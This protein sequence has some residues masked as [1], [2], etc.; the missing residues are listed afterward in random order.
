MD[1][2]V[3]FENHSSRVDR[4]HF[5]MRS[6]PLRPSPLA[7]RLYVLSATTLIGVSFFIEALFE[8]GVAIA[9]SV[10]F[11]A[12]I[13]VLFTYFFYRVI[14]HAKQQTLNSALAYTA[15]EPNS[16][17]LYLR[18]FATS[19]KIPVRNS[20]RSWTERAITGTFWD[21]EHSL[22]IALDAVGLLVAIGD[23]RNSFG[24]A[25]LLPTDAEWQA[26]FSDLASKSKNI[27]VV[28]HASPSVVWEVQTIVSDPNLV[29]KTWFLMP[30]SYW[31][32][33]RYALWVFSP[34]IIFLFPFNIINRYLAERRWR[35]A[36]EALAEKGI[37]LPLFTTSG[38]IFQLRAD[39]RVATH[40]PF[41]DLNS[42][43]LLSLLAR[44]QAAARQKVAKPWFDRFPLNWSPLAPGFAS[45]VVI[46]VSVMLP[47]LILFRSLVF[48]SFSIPSGS[49][50]P[51]LLIGDY[52]WVSK[53]A[54]GY[55]QSSFPHGFASFSG[56]IFSVEPKRGDVVVFKLSRDNSTF[57]IKRLIGLPGDQIE[58]RDGVLYINGSAVPKR[59]IGDFVR[60]DSDGRPRRS[61]QFEETLPN[62]IRYNV[63]DD[64]ANG[65]YDNV[66]PYKVPVGHYFMM[67]DNR[68]NSTD[69][70][71]LSPRVG[72]GYVPFDNFVGRADLV[73]FSV[74]WD[75]PDA[76]LWSRPWTWPFE[77]RWG[78]T[79]KRI[80]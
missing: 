8:S 24:A 40:T 68:D 12:A 37:A 7:R 79:F 63:L 44:P 29:R 78:R 65:P 22:S 48:Q 51:E 28:P 14:S 62:G 60:L 73:F 23:K 58:M 67:G 54:Y 16:F 21:I 50:K 70:R 38:L 57:Y 80:N 77:I 42:D 17:F 55:S 76:L 47:L 33:A 56:R 41:N 32:G 27:F 4:G 25:K 39:G 45:L 6:H 9:L 30:P 5:L 3:H 18:S 34:L 20:L 19:R 69:S 35:L 72:V 26:R 43:Y 49:M 46:S 75:E 11:A 74:P 10:I 64:I 2:M 52:L 13:F 15:L 66:G 71:E 59:R 53:P 1:C 61:P 31:R 36:T